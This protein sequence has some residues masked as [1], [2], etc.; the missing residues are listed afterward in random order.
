MHNAWLAF[1]ESNTSGTGRLFA[2]I[3]EQ[4][5][6][7]PALLAKDRTRYKYAD[8]DGLR[9]IQANT[10]DT[11]SVLKVCRQLADGCG[12]AGVTSSSE[13]FVEMAAEVAKQLGLP[14]PQPEAI[15]ACRDKLAQRVCL[16]RAGIGVPGF[17]PA[18]SSELA[19]EAAEA[20]GLP[21]VLKPVSGSGSVGVKMCGHLVNVRS[22]ATTLLQ[23]RM[24]ERGLPMPERILIEEMVVGPEY[25]VETFD[26]NVIGIT[27]KHLGPLPDFIE[28]GHDFPA[29][30]PH[31]TQAA[32][33]QIVTAALEALGLGWGPAHCELRLT[34][35]GM[36]IIEVNP[37]LAG[38]YIP[39][40]V[41]LA[42]GTEMITQTV[43]LVAGRHTH[44]DKTMNRYSSLRFIVANRDGILVRADNL[45]EARRL[46]GIVEV[47]LYSRI[48]DTVRR[49]SDFRARIGHVI[50]VTDSAE[51]SR[52][53]AEE[54]HSLVRLVIEAD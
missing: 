52:A 11:E 1:I 23:Q 44:L 27:Q 29:V 28:I 10:Q 18:G 37:R 39:E 35:Q 40:L 45:D 51:S 53:I 24:N 16:Q 9:V 26:R 3:A 34:E 50:A 13:Y 5:G 32:I 8:E 48:G 19:V 30:L 46:N 15:S 14:G 21:V 25:S 49:H 4:Q 31:E 17:I 54:A 7:Q 38:G 20:L 42:T 41:R 22:H 43:R 47:K 36:K 6:F 12:L 2:R 33:N